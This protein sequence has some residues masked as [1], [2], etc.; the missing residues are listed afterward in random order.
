MT[1]LIAVRRA[2]PGRVDDVPASATHLALQAVDLAGLGVVERAVD[3]GQ[4]DGVDW[5]RRS[6]TRD[7]QEGKDLE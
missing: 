6:G 7:V 2:R 3:V 1:R 5:Q 4:V